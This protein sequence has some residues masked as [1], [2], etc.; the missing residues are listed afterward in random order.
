[1]LEPHSHFLSLTSAMLMTEW[2]C[3]FLAGRKVVF[4]LCVSVLS[5]PSL[6]I[7]RPFPRPRSCVGVKPLQSSGRQKQP[8]GSA[9]LR[10]RS[11]SSVV[12]VIREIV[13]NISVRLP[14]QR[15][16]QAKALQFTLLRHNL[17]PLQLYGNPQDLLGTRRALHQLRAHPFLHIFHFH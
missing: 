10:P 3:V 6:R 11:T 5:P 8:C 15:A 14:H 7:F 17:T 4:S 2:L 1:M 16:A 13:Y 9:V 12:N